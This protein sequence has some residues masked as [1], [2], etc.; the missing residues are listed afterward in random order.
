MVITCSGVGGFFLLLVWLTSDKL[1]VMQSVVTDNPPRKEIGRL[2]GMFF[3]CSLLVPFVVNFQ[4]R[5]LS[6]TGG[7][8]KYKATQR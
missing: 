7:V 1:S 8:T 4:W 6:V 3:C 5:W 2:R